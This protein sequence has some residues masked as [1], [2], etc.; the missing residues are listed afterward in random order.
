MQDDGIIREN[1]RAV[2]FLY[3]KRI[4]EASPK[5]A[6]NTLLVDII[7]LITVM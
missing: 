7:L 5:I 2:K 4:Y 1:C 6:L 3:D